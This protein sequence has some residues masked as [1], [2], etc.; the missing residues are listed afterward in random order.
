[1][2]G[3]ECVYKGK[4]F[5]VLRARDGKLF[6]R[7]RGRLSLKG[8]GPVELTRLEAEKLLQEQIQK[9][10]RVQA[11]PNGLKSVR[12]GERTGQAKP[13]SLQRPGIERRWKEK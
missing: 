10:L 11:E 4:D 5:E 1:M 13:G 6:L 2:K 7:V 9:Q 8:P 12:R 3:C